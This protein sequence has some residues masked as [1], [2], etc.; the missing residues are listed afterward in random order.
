MKRLLVFT[1][2]LSCAA[3]TSSERE[4]LSLNLNTSE[5]QPTV[6]R[7]E[8]NDTEWSQAGAIQSYRITAQ[9]DERV[10]QSDQISL[11]QL[12]AF[13]LV[14][15][16][17]NVET[18]VRVSAYSTEQE[19][20]AESESTITTGVLSDELRAIDVQVQ[21]DSQFQGFFY[22]TVFSDPAHLVILDRDGRIVWGVEH[23]DE[24]HTAALTR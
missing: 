3:S 2:S 14:G 16:P 10:F 19:L 24:T 15:A 6:V 22:G 12:R 20:L 11:E 13:R 4:A 5:Q 7:V 21:R 18:T 23:G 1:F 8:L 9:W 17:P